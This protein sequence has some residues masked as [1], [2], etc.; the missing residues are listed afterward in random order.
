VVILAGTLLAGA[1][2]TSQG[3]GATFLTK[4]KG[5]K[6]YVN[7]GERASDAELLD[8]KDSD[9]FLTSDQAPGFVSE[10]ETFTRHW[11]CHGAN[12]DAEDSATGYAGRIYRYR[13]GTGG[14]SLFQCQ[15]H[16]PH[17]AV[18]TELAFALHDD[19]TSAAAGPC[20][21]GRIDTDGTGFGAISTVAEVGNTGDSA[22]PFRI[23][24]VDT[25]LT[26]PVID[27]E[28]FTY[29]VECQLTSADTDV[30]IY[31]AHVTYTVTGANL[32]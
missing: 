22:A 26:N 17:G 2:S 7:V 8:G 11:G 14:E 29:R 12:F 20:F 5:N 27:N 21:M 1:L 3:F 10:E 23:R 4:K 6:L 31:G 25:M 19:D 32:G 16:L 15:V 9:Q 13:V 30:G 28:G 24:L 18:V